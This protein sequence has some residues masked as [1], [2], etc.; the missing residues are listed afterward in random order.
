MFKVSS[1]AAFAA[2]DVALSFVGEYLER[3]DF[4]PPG[5]DHFDYFLMGVFIDF[6]LPEIHLLQKWHVLP[7][8]VRPFIRP[9][10]TLSRLLHGIQFFHL[11]LLKRQQQGLPIVIEVLF[12]ALVLNG[13]VSYSCEVSSLVDVV[14]ADGFQ[15]IG[16]KVFSL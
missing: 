4:A 13:Q 14:L 15:L 3:A 5:I 1:V 6:L 16:H 11:I 7:R 10:F 9:L 12:Q 2:L 8:Q